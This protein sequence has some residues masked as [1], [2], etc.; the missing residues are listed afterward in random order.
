MTKDQIL[1]CLIESSLFPSL[2]TERHSIVAGPVEIFF[3]HSD[4]MNPGW[5]YR[6]G[7]ESGS[8]DSLDQVKALAMLAW[9]A[10][11]SPFRAA[12]W[13]SP[14]GQSEIVLT[15]SDQAHLSDD[16]LI[17]AGVEWAE[18]NELESQ[19]DHITLQWWTP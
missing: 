16:D 10:N 9:D 8:I 19:H 14:D 1:G 13:T 15:T 18:A 4:P 11:P 2:I 12:V 6:W 5:A 3:D 7:I 17:A